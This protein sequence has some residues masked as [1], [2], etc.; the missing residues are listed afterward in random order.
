[1][2]WR[3]RKG[4]PCERGGRGGRGEWSLYYTGY[5][6]EHLKYPFEGEIVDWQRV[7]DFSKHSRSGLHRAQ[8]AHLVTIPE[9][10]LPNNTYIP[11]PTHNLNAGVTYYHR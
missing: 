4:S 10:Y 1:M 7:T 3:D 8:S 11:K 2:I 6:M 5:A 9:S